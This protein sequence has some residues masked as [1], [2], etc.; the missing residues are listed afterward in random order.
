MVT[1]SARP[2][3]YRITFQHFKLPGKIGNGTE[4]GTGIP[5]KSVINRKL[6]FQIFLTRSKVNKINV[7][8]R[9]QHSICQVVL[10]NLRS[11]SNQHFHSCSPLSSAMCLFSGKIEHKITRAL[12]HFAWPWH[13]ALAVWYIFAAISSQNQRENSR[14]GL[15]SDLNLL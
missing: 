11:N 6:S 9:E 15:F 2:P 5:G 10:F 14:A 13:L 1:R 8:A 3:E 12:S 7:F 4:I